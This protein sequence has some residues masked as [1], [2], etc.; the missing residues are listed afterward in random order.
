[1]GSAATKADLAQVEARLETKIEQL[2]TTLMTWFL[3]TVLTLAAI[4][5]APVKL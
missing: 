1:M 3:G 4:I 5:I 2:R